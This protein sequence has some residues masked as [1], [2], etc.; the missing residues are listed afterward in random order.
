MAKYRVINRFKDKDN[1]G[2]VY[3]VGDSYPGQGRK[4]NVKRAEYLTK[5]HPKYGVAFLVEEEPNVTEE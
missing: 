5:P 1:N 2:K 3:E 4:L